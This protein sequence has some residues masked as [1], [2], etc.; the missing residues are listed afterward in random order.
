MKNFVL[1]FL[2]L[3]SCSMFSQVQ[4]FQYAGRWNPVVKKEKLSKAKFISDLADNF[5]NKVILI[6]GDR[7]ELEH[8][9]NMDCS[10]RY[11]YHSTNSRFSNTFLFSTVVISAVKAGK[12]IAYA[13]KSD[14]LSADQKDLLNSLELGEDL[15]ITI[16]FRYKY[17]DSENKKILEDL[18]EGKI[19]ITLVPEKEAEYK[20]G[21]KEFV[22]FI[23]ENI[24]NKFNEKGSWDKMKV[25]EVKF[26]VDERGNVKEGRVTKKCLD[27]K[28]DQAILDAIRKMPDWIPAKNAAGKNVAEEF[29]I[30][31]GGWGGC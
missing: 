6:K 20:G 9:K 7:K 16:K 5:W 11:F 31:F 4:K 8:Q 21:A 13:S 25:A 15:E 27:S 2:L 28:M 19:K 23:N 30:P 14:E 22:K 3:V 26:R 10:Q 12:L 1:V 17:T 29:T 18:N 24:A